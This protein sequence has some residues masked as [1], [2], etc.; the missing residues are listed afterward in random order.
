MEAI[1]APLQCFKV[2]AVVVETSAMLL[3][4]LWQVSKVCFQKDFNND[5]SN[6]KTVCKSQ[7]RHHANEIAYM[8]E[9]KVNYLIHSQNWAGHMDK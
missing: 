3:I 5:L 2:I 4:N 1:L 7:I 9:K 8:V 6:I